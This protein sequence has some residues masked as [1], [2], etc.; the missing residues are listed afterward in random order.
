MLHVHHIEEKKPK[1]ER[2]EK[3]NLQL[4]WVHPLQYPRQ[5]ENKTMLRNLGYS[6]KKKI[7][8]NVAPRR[9]PY[10]LKLCLKVVLNQ[11]RLAADISSMAIPTSW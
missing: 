8:H 10:V 3:K 4:D 6:F 1:K 2:K 11:R 7:V 5:T 9:K